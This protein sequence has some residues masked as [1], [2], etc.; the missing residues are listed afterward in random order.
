M[1]SFLTTIARELND[2]AVHDLAV[3]LLRNVWGLP[4]IVQTIHIVSVAVLMASVVFINLRILGLAVPSQ[5]VAEM[6]QRLLPWTWTALV[7]LLLSGSVFI[8]ARPLRYFTNPVFGWKLGMLLAT[9]AITFFMLR[10]IKNSGTENKTGAVK[11]FAA[12]TLLLW[13]TIVFAGRWI[14]YADY[15]FPP[16]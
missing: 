11:I 13:I 12:I 15:L 3:N 10:S 7:L 9:L 2:S 6:K 4:P 14:A 16:S 1:S 8:V 5:N